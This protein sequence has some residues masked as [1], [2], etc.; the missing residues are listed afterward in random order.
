MNTVHITPQVQQF[1]AA[2]RDRLTDLSQDER[3]ELIGGLEA[4]MSDLVA[5]RGEAALPDPVVYAAELRAAA[6]FAAEAQTRPNRLRTSLA[7]RFDGA[8]LTWR[9]WVETGV[10]AGL[11]ALLESLRPLWWVLRA[12]SATVL[13]VEIFGSQSVYGVTFNRALL[14]GVLILLSVQLGRGAWWPATVLQRSVSLRVLLLALNVFALVLLPVMFARFFS[15]HDAYGYGYGEPVSYPDSSTL[16]TFRGQPIR[17]IYAYDAKGQPLTGIQLVDEDGARLMVEPDQYDDD[18]GVERL[19]TPWM[20]GR[21]ELYSVFPLPEQPKDQ[22]T[23]D[24]TGTAG[25]QPPPFASL[26][27][28]TLAGV[29]PSVLV[30]AADAAT[31][32]NTGKQAA[33]KSAKKQ[34]TRPEQPRG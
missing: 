20:N 12:L 5:E 8:A 10:H 33:K 22:Q 14:A 13:V 3:E 34:Q 19:L 25:L 15:A 32:K 7:D 28:V 24:P 6:G 17:N 11:P 30:P 31:E 23:G 1:V 9:R 27:P 16:L 21:T 18:S 2:V 29:T 4:D 26:P